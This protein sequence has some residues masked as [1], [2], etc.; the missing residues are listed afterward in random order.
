MR[1]VN[2]V[3]RGE[4]RTK[5]NHQRILGGGGRCPKCGKPAK[6]WIAQSAAYQDYEKAALLQLRPRPAEPIDAPVQLV[7]H[8]YMRTRRKVDDLNLYG[9]LDDILVRAG[10]L[11]DDNTRIIGSRDGSRV[12]YDKDEPRV[13][14]TII[15]IQEEQ[16]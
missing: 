11:A 10:I 6:Q 14:I 5:K 8:V 12:R 7:Y 13:E 2:Y 16:K 3:I 15:P 1:A 4:P 9:A